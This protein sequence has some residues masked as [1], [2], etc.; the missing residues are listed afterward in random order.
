MSGL[1]RL[2]NKAE[3]FPRDKDYCTNLLELY[4][5]NHEKG[6]PQ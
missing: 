4:K 3:R 5:S 6:T 2:Q 1:E